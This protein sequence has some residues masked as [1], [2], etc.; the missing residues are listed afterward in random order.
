MLLYSLLNGEM[1]HTA[2]SSI[3]L[4]YRI[5]ARSRKGAIKGLTAKTRVSK[6]VNR[7]REVQIVLLLCKK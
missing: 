4:T 7:T 3:D 1:L 2:S 6:M 5:K